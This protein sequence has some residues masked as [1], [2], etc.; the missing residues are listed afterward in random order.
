MRP[1]PACRS[2]GLEQAF[3]GD[4]LPAYRCAACNGVWLRAQ[5]YMAWQRGRDSTRPDAPLWARE[6]CAASLVTDGDCAKLCPDCGRFLRR[7]KIWP[8]ADLHL[9]RCSACNGVWFDLREWQALK[10][11]GFGSLYRCMET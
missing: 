8:D 10:K 11:K 4:D 3:L 6:A 7:Y 5:E 1:C 2:D 9:E